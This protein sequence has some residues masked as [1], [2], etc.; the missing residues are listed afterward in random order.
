M[1]E[2]LLKTVTKHF[3]D[4]NQPYLVFLYR[5]L[6]STA[7]YGLFRLSKLMSGTLGSHPIQARDVHI[8]DNKRKMLFALRTSKTHG[9]DVEP[10][11]VKIERRATSK[12][13][14]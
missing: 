5:A 4:I 10:Q 9:E 1:L 2:V 12:L 14:E 3:T 13:K 11:I 7:Y 6:F 8:G